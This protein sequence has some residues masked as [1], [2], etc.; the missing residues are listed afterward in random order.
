MRPLPA[1]AKRPI[2]SRSPSAPGASS[3]DAPAPP[4]APAD[5]AAKPAAPSDAAAPAV[6]RPPGSIENRQA[7]RIRRKSRAQLLLFP[8]GRHPHP[9]DVTVVDYSATGIGIVHSEGLLVGQKFIVREPHV[10]EGNTCLFTVVRSDRRP[11]GTYSIGLHIGNS[12]TDELEP[13]VA[14]PPAPGLSRWDKL[15]FLLFAL[16]GATT[17]VLWAILQHRTQ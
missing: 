14:I 1:R 13:M 15:L 12:L 6:A 10:T 5:E 3:P 7:P 16:L 9:I 2:F 8:S 11:D 4:S 17:V